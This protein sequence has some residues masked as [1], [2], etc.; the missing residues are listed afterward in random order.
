MKTYKER[1]PEIDK[2]IFDLGGE[3]PPYVGDTSD[4]SR[5][6]LIISTGNHSRGAGIYS[7]SNFGAEHDNV[8]W[9]RIC[10]RTEFEARVADWRRLYEWCDTELEFKEFIQLKPRV[11][12]SAAEEERVNWQLSLEGKPKSD[13]FENGDWPPVGEVVEFFLP[14]DIAM[15]KSHSKWEI[16]D[17]VEVIAIKDT[18]NDFDAC[19]IVWNIRLKEA[20]N[21]IFDCLRPLRTERDELIEKAERIIEEKANEPAY[22]HHL[23]ILY[24]AGMLKEPTN[25]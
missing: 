20:S 25:D 17:K 1:L 2:A 19:C 12:A 9:V 22:S 11:W 15:D 13:W 24:E 21:L 8:T 4:F 7:C 10:T 18:G 23:K 6:F 5:P 16:G 3:W 14:D